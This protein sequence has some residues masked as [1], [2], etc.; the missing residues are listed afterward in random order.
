MIRPETSTDLLAIHALVA[1]AFERADEANL[2]EALR[3]AG[4]LPI[5]LLYEHS[6][7]IVGHVGFGPVTLPEQTKSESCGMGLAPL[8]VEALSRR[9]GIGAAL[10]RAGVEACRARGADFVVVLG[11]PEYY[12][13]FGFQAAPRFG[14]R[15]EYG[16]GDAFQVMELRTGGIPRDAGLVRYAPQFAEL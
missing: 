8:A 3:A 10:I 6:G 12:Q 2:V 14:L 15:D 13:R 7:R 9:R 5:S 4:N 11:E 1:A 16:G